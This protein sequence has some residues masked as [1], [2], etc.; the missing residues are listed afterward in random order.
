MASEYIEIGV[1]VEYGKTSSHRDA[2]DQAINE[3][4]D[5]FASAAA[6]SIHRSGLIEIDDLG[7]HRFCPREEASEI[8]KMPLVSRSSEDLHSHGIAAHNL[9]TEKLIDAQAHRTTG[10]A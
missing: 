10:I 5:R 8:T 7:G 3:F 1:G 9:S 2:R 6:G 4:A